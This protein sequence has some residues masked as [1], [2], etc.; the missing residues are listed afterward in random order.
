MTNDIVLLP[1]PASV[2]WIHGHLATRCEKVSLGK[3]GTGLRL[4][5]DEE[6]FRALTAQMIGYLEAKHTRHQLYGATDVARKAFDQADAF[7]VT[8]SHVFEHFFRGVQPMTAAKRVARASYHSGYMDAVNELRATFD[9][10][11][12]EGKTLEKTSIEW[13]TES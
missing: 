6:F 4:L 8:M 1:V 2:D 5:E 13:K 3:R 9:A 7:T 10:L 11:L 12:T